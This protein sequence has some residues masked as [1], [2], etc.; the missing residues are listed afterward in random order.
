RDG[1]HRA[2]LA[3]LLSHV[4]R[5]DEEAK[6]Y[7][8]ARET[9][10]VLA[11]GTALGKRRPAWVMAAELVETNRLRARTV[12]QISPDRIEQAARH[13]VTRSH[14]EPWWDRER[15]AAMTSERVSLYGLP[16][17]SSRRVA[18]DRVDPAG[19]RELFIRHALVAGEWD[20]P[21]AF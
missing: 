8:G 2:L 16:I 11:G 21:H 18:Y 10:F 12:A 6:E 14:G 20:A 9:R 3:G 17:V 19:A 5:W 13:L 1:I 4:G 7:R 15:G